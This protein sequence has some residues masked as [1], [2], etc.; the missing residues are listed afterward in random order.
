MNEAHLQLTKLGHIPSAP[1]AAATTDQQRAG[2]S[3]FFFSLQT[4]KMKFRS[5]THALAEYLIHRFATTIIHIYT[6]VVSSFFFMYISTSHIAKYFW[7]LLSS[8]RDTQLFPCLIAFYFSFFLNIEKDERLKDLA[9]AGGVDPAAFGNPK[10]GTLDDKKNVPLKLDSVSMFHRRRM[11]GTLN[12]ISHSQKKV[13][14]TTSIVYSPS[15]SSS[16]NQRT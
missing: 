14:M 11:Y 5:L 9:P 6:D 8:C 12:L 16:L 1:S 3:S 10:S 2:S 13:V 7:H 4:M 15:S